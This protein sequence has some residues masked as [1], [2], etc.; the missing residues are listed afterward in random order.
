MKVRKDEGEKLINVAAFF[1]Y[2]AVSTGIDFLVLTAT[3]DILSGSSVPSTTIVLATNLPCAICV[4]TLPYFAG[5]ISQLAASASIFSLFTTGLL[6]VALP[7]QLEL[8]LTGAACIGVGTA[9]SDTIFLGFTAR[10]ADTTVHAYVSGAG[11]AGIIA[12]VFYTG[13]FIAL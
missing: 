11:L 12:N 10:Y 8:R 6:L 2:G 7:A 5:R 9:M 13:K 1:I 4:L 3:E